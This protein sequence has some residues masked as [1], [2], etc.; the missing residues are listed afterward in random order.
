MK[1]ATIIG[2]VILAAVTAG[3]VGASAQAA[4]PG[5][6]PGIDQLFER[7]DTDGD[8]QISQAE[9]EAAADARFA[10]SDT[11]GDGVLSAEELV[12]AAEGRRAER[13][14]RRVARMIE[15]LDA[16]DSGTLSQEELQA[17][18]RG[19]L[20]ERLDADDDGVVTREEVAAARDDRP[21][22]PGRDGGRGPGPDHGHGHGH[23]PRH[24]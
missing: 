18:R 7:F 6:R 24:N 13:V 11:D 15:R 23:G 20:F 22:R 8:G 14:A 1:R 16:D 12:A 19:D 10:D 3:S 17:G 9:F 5:P 2:T 21:Q 4:G